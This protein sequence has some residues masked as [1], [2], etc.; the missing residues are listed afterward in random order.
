[1]LFIEDYGIGEENLIY[2]QKK[3]LIS[4][5]TRTLALRNIKR[6]HHYSLK[7]KSKL[8]NLFQ[9]L[10]LKVIAER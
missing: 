4:Q 1:M 2:Y 5:F 8:R 3:D 10:I 9:T 7:T 6:L